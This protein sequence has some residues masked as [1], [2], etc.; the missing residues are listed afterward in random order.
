M[1]VKG[2]SEEYGGKGK[3]TSFRPF[4]KYSPEVGVSRG[5][6]KGTACCTLG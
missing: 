1:L 5:R 2:F 6:G 4:K 3:G